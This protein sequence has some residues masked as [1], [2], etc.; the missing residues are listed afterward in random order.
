MNKFLKDLEKELNKLKINKSDIKEILEDHKEMIDAAKNDGL[1][2]KQIEEKFG[3]PEKLAKDIFEDTSDINEKASINFDDVDSCVN[4]STDKYNLVKVFPV[5][6]DK[7]SVNIGLA[8]TDLSFTAY[9]GDS[10]QVFEKDVKDIKHYTISFEN[11]LFTLKRNKSQVLFN[12]TR[13]SARFLVLVPNT[14][15]MNKFE[16]KTVSGDANINAIATTDFYIK[17][18][19]GDIQI[20]NLESVKIKISTVSGDMKMARVKGEALEISLISGDLKLEKTV[21][22]GEINFHSVSGD[23]FLSEVEC[24][25]A[26]VKTVS[27]DI[28]GKEF[29]PSEI[30]LKSVSGDINIANMDKNKKITVLSK[31]SVSG[32][33]EIN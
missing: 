3:N 29:Y 19:S 26:H 1:D 16:Y 21:I 15:E 33:I 27:G 13:R 30:S 22:D 6:T 12:F 20:T 24:K 18:T 32:D 11:E 5:V 10:I 8:F 31:K 17:S 7:F 9:E 25:E 23:V 28:K 2:E 4:E 14:V